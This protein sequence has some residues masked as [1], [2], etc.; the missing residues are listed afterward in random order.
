MTVLATLRCESFVVRLSVHPRLAE[1]KT[2]DNEE[3]SK[4]TSAIPGAANSDEEEKGQNPF[5]HNRPLPAS[6]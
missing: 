1:S 4:C 6:V 3:E 5:L 2:T